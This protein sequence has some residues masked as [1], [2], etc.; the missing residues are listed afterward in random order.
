MWSDEFNYEGGPDPTKWTFDIGTGSG[1]WGNNELQYYTD[2][3]ENAFVK[4]GVLSIRALKKSFQGKDYTSA[5][6]KTMNRVDWKYGRIQIRARLAKGVARGTWSALWMLPT[7]NRYGAWPNSGE[8]D[9]M[10]HVGYDQGRIH[11]TVHTAAYNHM[12]GTQKGG[13]VLAG[14]DG[15][16]VYEIDWKQDRIDFILDGTLYYVF[17][18]NDPGTSREWPFDQDFHLI[19]N[20]AV[21]GSWGGVQGVDQTAFEGDGQ[22]MEVDWVRVYSQ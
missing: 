3:L 11:G 6:I 13:Q 7:D 19:F 1:G 15:W 2:S 18:R 17:S 8:I 4:D 12:L 9:I 21:G 10:E 16:H 14:L 5:R 20:I 22:V